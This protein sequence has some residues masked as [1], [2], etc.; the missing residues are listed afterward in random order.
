MKILLWAVS[1]GF[2]GCILWII[3]M[4]IFSES[5]NEDF[6]DNNYLYFSPKYIY[7]CTEMNIVGCILT[8]IF[9]FIVDYGYGII[10][11]TY[12]FLHIGRK[13]K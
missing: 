4:L 2:V 3:N 5:G 13:N 7:E 8:G 9:L 1:F 12:Y 11:L 6:I 10:A